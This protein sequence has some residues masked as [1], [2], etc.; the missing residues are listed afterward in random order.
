MADSVRIFV[1]LKDFVFGIF[2]HPFWVLPVY[3]DKQKTAPKYIG[4][5]PKMLIFAGANK[6]HPYVRIT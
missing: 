6:K 3:Y 5:E 2:I 4:A 1:N